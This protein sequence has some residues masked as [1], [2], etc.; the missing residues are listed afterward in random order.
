M[1][2]MGDFDRSHPGVNMTPHGGCMGFLGKGE[3]CGNPTLKKMY[4]EKNCREDPPTWKPRN[5]SLVYGKEGEGLG[6]GVS[7]GGGRMEG[8]GGCPSLWGGGVG[9]RSGGPDTIVGTRW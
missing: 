7:P 5:G 9:C 3:G 4:V 1:H 8:D 6:P 2:R